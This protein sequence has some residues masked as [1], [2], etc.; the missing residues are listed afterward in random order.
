MRLFSIG[1][2]Y[3]GTDKES[4]WDFW[5]NSTDVSIHLGII[6]VELDRPHSRN[7]GS[8]QKGTNKPNNGEASQGN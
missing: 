2:L 8:L 7:H 4:F 3:I 6:R 1:P 5:I